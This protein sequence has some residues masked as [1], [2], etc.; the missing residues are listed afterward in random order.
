MVRCFCTWQAAS[1]PSRARSTGRDAARGAASRRRE[2]RSR[3]SPRANIESVFSAFLPKLLRPV[4]G[5][6]GDV[7]IALV[8]QGLVVHFLSFQGVLPG[9]RLD[10]GSMPVDDPRE[11]G[12]GRQ[13]ADAWPHSP[14]RREAQNASA[15]A[16]S[17]KRTSSEPWRA[18]AI[19]S[20]RVRA[21]ASRVEGSERRSSRS[22]DANRSSRGSSIAPSPTSFANASTRTRVPDHGPITSRHWT[23]PEPSQIEASGASR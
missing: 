11:V 2:H 12:A 16:S 5:E 6:H 7:P 10:R 13:R 19:R 3:A 22:L 23:F 8:A 9:G 21:R 4:V 17:P 20:T 15:T 14:E 1:A 18:S